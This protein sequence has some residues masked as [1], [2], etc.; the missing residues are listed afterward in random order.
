M[1]KWIF[2]RYEKK[3]LQFLH[4]KN[5]IKLTKDNLTISFHDLDGNAYYKFPKGIELPLSRVSKMQEYMMWMQK[6]FD[7]K[8]YLE[9]LDYAESGLENGIKDGKGLSKI[10]FILGQ[11]RERTKMIIHDELFYNIIAIQVIRH[12]ESV[13]D[14][15]NDIHMQKVEMFKK[16]NKADDTFFLATQEYLEAFGLLNTTKSQLDKLLHES[17]VLRESLSK[18]VSST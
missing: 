13:T 7:S 15:S 4:K 6:G 17:R 10:G 11:F 14:F 8:E 9:A 3:F 16:M 12:D 2:N 18:L 1:L 5:G